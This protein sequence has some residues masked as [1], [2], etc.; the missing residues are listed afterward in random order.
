MDIVDV[1]VRVEQQLEAAEQRRLE[2]RLRQV[3]G[4]I[5]PRFNAPHSHLLLVA[6]NPALLDSRRLLGV[7]RDEGFAAQLVGM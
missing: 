4:V 3:E 1:V 7:V 6:Y 5:A 2:E